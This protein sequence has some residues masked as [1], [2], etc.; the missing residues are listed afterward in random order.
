MMSWVIRSPSC[1]Q[2]EDLGGQVLV[3]G[4]GAQ[5]LVE[6]RGRPQHVLPGLLEQLEV[7]AVPGSEHLSEAR[8]ARRILVALGIAGRGGRVGAMGATHSRPAWKRASSSSS[9]EYQCSGPG[10]LP[11]RTS[12]AYSATP[13]TMCARTSP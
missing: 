5:Q 1:S 7:H 9:I 11:L 3:V 8:H 4:V 6:Q 13:A 12:A 2:V 10:K